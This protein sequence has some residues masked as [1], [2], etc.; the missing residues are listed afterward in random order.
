MITLSAQQRIELIEALAEGFTPEA[1]ERRVMDP[2]Q[3]PPHIRTAA[4]DYRARIAALTDWAAA[5]RRMEDLLRTAYAA[6]LYSERL[7]MLNEATG[8]VAATSGLVEAIRPA[9]PKDGEKA[10]NRGLA[11]VSKQVC[12]VGNR[13]QAQQ[14]GRGF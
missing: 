9:L 2:M 13:G 11:E 5:G 3:V 8:L 4:R 12:L 1:L 6:N 7:R 10:W 14:P